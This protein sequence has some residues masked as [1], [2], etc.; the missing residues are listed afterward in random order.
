MRTA[1]VVVAV[2][3]SESPQVRISPTHIRWPTSLAWPRVCLWTQK[4][5]G[6][7]LVTAGVCATPFPRSV[8]ENDDP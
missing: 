4:E 1:E 2:L 8:M 6:G 3:A 5:E 7:V